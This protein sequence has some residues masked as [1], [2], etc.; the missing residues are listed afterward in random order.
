MAVMIKDVLITRE[1]A[2]PT[3]QGVKGSYSNWED[4][5]DSLTNWEAVKYDNV[6]IPLTVTVG[7]RIV[8]TVTAVDV[9]WNVIRK[10]FTDWNEI[11]GLSNWKSV[12]NY[13]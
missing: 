7:E 13:H 11:A 2:T 4:V 3:W 12:M 5:K 8:V 1:G 6:E 9:D 10:E